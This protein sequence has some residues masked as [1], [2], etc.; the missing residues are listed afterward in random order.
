MNAPT[1][2]SALRAPHVTA[3]DVCNVLRAFA[4]LPASHEELMTIVASLAAM[5]KKPSAL[6]DACTAV[7]VDMLDEVVGQIEQDQ[8]DQQVAA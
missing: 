6:G 8:V 3:N 2:Y 7:I 1:P 5:L 4:Q